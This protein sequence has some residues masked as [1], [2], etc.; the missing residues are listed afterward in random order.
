MDR[1]LIRLKTTTQ[2]PSKNGG[3]SEK[4]RF[5]AIIIIIIIITA[6]TKQSVTY[7]KRSSGMALYTNHHDTTYAAFT[8]S[9][10]KTLRLRYAAT[11]VSM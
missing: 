4:A 3:P 5:A 11:K 9:H 6:E 7:R 10:H 2:A 1:L 8:A